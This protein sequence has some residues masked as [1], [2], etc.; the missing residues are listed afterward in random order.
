MRMPDRSF[1]VELEVQVPEIYSDPA[2]GAAILRDAGIDA[3]VLGYSHETTPYWKVTTDSS[4]IEGY[5]IVSPILKGVEGLA[6]VSK[7][8]EA[9]T[10]ASF[11]VNATCGLHVHVDARDF[12]YQAIVRLVRQFLIEEHNFDKFVDPSRLNNS[13]C[14]SNISRFVSTYDDPIATIKRA[15][16]AVGHGARN[17]YNRVAGSRYYKLNL[18]ALESA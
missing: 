18:D 11:T 1:G 10:D 7:V 3:H 16:H 6:Q 17:I 12:D 9:L 2:D 8:C 4:V 15:H 14:L 13:F 5:E